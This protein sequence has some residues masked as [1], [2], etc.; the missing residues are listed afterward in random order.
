V[1]V[2]AGA[3]PPTMAGAE[4]AATDSEAVE[5]EAQRVATRTGRREANIEDR[6]RAALTLLGGLEVLEDRRANEWRIEIDRALG[7]LV[8]SVLDAERGIASDGAAADRERARD[9]VVAFLLTFST[10]SASRERLHVFSTNYDR[11]VEWTCDHAG[12]QVIDRFVGA[13]EPVFRSSR[14]DVD[15][16]YNPPGIRG[17][18]RYLEG[19]V[20]LTKLHGL[21]LERRRSSTPGTALRCGWR[22]QRGHHRSGRP[23]ADLA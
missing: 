1:S 12:V 3:V 21:A 7:E 10:R 17:E 2:A 14:L 22:P 19:V 13:L 4:F 9:L 23:P 18:P 5:R 11:L 16:H 15:L 20:R 6:L 8:R